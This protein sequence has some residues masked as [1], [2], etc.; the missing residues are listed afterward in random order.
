MKH[1]YS[2]FDLGHEPSS[3]KNYK[4]TGSTSFVETEPL[5][6]PN[7]GRRRKIV[8]ETE[9]QGG[10]K[11][12]TVSLTK[13]KLSV[14]SVS[15]TSGGI[16]AGEE[17][18][19]LETASLAS[20]YSS[21]IPTRP[22][23]R[24]MIS[25]IGQFEKTSALVKIVTIV[26]L[27][28]VIVVAGLCVWTNT[29]MTQKHTATS[30]DTSKMSDFH[31]THYWTFTT[32]TAQSFNTKTIPP[33]Q[34]NVTPQTKI[35]TASST[36]TSTTTTTSATT[37]IIESK[38]EDSLPMIKCKSEGRQSA[39][40]IKYTKCHHKIE[41]TRNHSRLFVH[42]CGYYFVILSADAECYK[43]K[44]VT[45]EI[46]LIKSDGTV[47]NLQYPTV[48]HQA[49]LAGFT[50]SSP[51]AGIQVPYMNPGD[52]IR[53]AVQEADGDN[54]IINVSVSMFKL[55]TNVFLKCSKTETATDEGRIM[56]DGGCVGDSI[57][58]K[59]N[60]MIRV[61]DAGVYYVCLQADIYTHGNYLFE[62]SLDRENGTHL[63]V[64]ASGHYNSNEAGYYAGQNTITDCKLIKLSAFEAI[65]TTI[66]YTKEGNKLVS[67]EL[68]MF[69][70]LS[71]WMGCY[72][73]SDTGRGLD[74]GLVTYT[75][76]VSSDVQEVHTQ[77]SHFM[78]KKSGRY[79]VS[80][81]AYANDYNGEFYKIHMKKGDE[82]M[83][84]IG[85]DHEDNHYSFEGGSSMY[86]GEVWELAEGDKLYV[87]ITGSNNDTNVQ[88][89]NKNIF[90]LH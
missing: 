5:V 51:L 68:F 61:K 55:P 36:T 40:K 63:L 87:E 25:L 34:P 69:R 82:E 8:Y 86:R 26:I 59:D 52:A 73:F 42:S 7:D 54:K 1:M 67:A 32:K 78:V 90:A 27:L 28:F 60:Q 80:L 50:G 71:D 15:M 47:I 21:P 16:G 43:N 29:N 13:E 23:S 10:M 11:K 85:S 45:L 31:T 57:E 77:P 9:L 83:F 89:V 4:E 74:R 2:E 79:Y 24:F 81:S 22:M 39:G 76:C 65:Q 18:G 58:S 46:Q 3:R 6:D 64:L 19:A 38:L 84:S 75:S 14:L 35:G 37:V 66:L 53:T 12:T 48:H 49:K 30:K 20:K 88:Y 44:L 41:I 33:P 17:A 56:F 62:L 72:W 70:V